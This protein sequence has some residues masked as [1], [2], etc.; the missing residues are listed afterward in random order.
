[1]RNLRT[2][3]LAVFLFLP[4]YAVGEDCR[5]HVESSGDYSLCPPDGW[6]AEL[7]GEG[8]YHSFFGSAPGDLQPNINVYDEL[9]DLPLK[10]YA[11]AGRAQ[12]VKMA[13]EAGFSRVDIVNN[14]DFVTQSK[15][16]AVRTVY[17]SELKNVQIATVQYT[18]DGTRGRKIIVTCTM[19]E[20]EKATFT[21]ICDRALKT[22]RTTK[23]SV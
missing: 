16:K 3:T 17:S 11:A 1:M 9:N 20:A 21:P 4:V 19:P 22:Y 15:E 23:K 13:K 14:S 18:F 8:R 5:R 12:A 6:E 10:K 2:V 7:P